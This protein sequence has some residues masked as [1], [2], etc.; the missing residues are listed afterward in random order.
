MYVLNPWHDTN[1][2]KQTSQDFKGKEIAFEIINKFIP[3]FKKK[4]YP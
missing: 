1:Y 2:G 3:F 4:Y